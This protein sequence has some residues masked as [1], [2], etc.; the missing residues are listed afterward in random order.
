MS[1]RHPASG[2]DAGPACDR[3]CCL[4]QEV[5]PGLL[6]G[7]WP[8]GLREPADILK[9]P[10]VIDAHAMFSWE[11]WLKTAGLTGA[12]MTV[13]H[14]FNDASL[15]LDA[16]IARAGGDACLA[17]A[18]R[19]RAAERV[20]RGRPFGIR[21]KT[22]FGHYFVTSVSRESKGAAAFKRWVREEVEDECGSSAR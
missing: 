4:E 10:A 8:S 15:A 20:S 3:N 5:F 13:R 21:A 22:G 14:T 11:L 7:H 1:T 9:L 18:C 2:L 12:A 17:D 16:A 6:A 19:I